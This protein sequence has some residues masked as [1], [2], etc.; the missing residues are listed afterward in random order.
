L[1][2]QALEDITQGKAISTPVYNFIDGSSSHDM[3]G[4]LKPG[5]VP[6]EI[7]PADIIFIEGN[8][9]FLIEEILHLIGIKVVY[10]TDDHVRMKRKWKRDMD[11]RKK[12]DLSY[13]RNRYFKDQ[14]IMAQFAYI[15]QLEVCD[16]CVDTSGA[17]LW[18]TPEVAEILV[19]G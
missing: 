15:P 10:L 1:F 8:F 13:F 14:F 5:R 4:R 7:E 9:P 3:A 12:Y 2:K 6:L 16:L 11:Y 18:A 17:A 19:R